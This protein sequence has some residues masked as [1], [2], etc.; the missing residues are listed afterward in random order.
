MRNNGRYTAT[1]ELICLGGGDLFKIAD[2]CSRHKDITFPGH[3]HASLYD[4][5]K[6]E[7]VVKDYLLDLGINLHMESR[8][9]DINKEGNKLKGIYLADESYYEADVFIETTGTTGPM[10]NCL[11][12]GNGCSMC[13][14]RCPSFGPRIS[15]SERCGVADIQGERADDSLGAMSGSCKLSKESLSDSIR[16]ELDKNGVVVLKIPEE[17]INY[18]KLK[19]KVCQQYALKEFAEN[20]VLLDTGHARCSKLQHIMLQFL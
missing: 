14:L 20:I 19:S 6:I 8:V 3:L 18:D 12:Y 17:D 4:V 5:N 2:K 1:E 10:G 7:G 13:V 9:S 11:R 16:D 15:I